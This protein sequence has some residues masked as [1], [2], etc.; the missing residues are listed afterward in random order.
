MM[1]K[2][3]KRK[4]LK[5]DNGE[6][7]KM[8]K[9]RKNRNKEKSNV[10]KRA[11]DENL[12]G[13]KKRMNQWLTL[14]LIVMPW[15]QSRWVRTGETPCFLCTAFMRYSGFHTNVIKSFCPL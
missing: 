7:R 9:G 14:Q 1:N 13:R 10:G 12:E 3:G 11:G 2:I 6:K 4:E 8:K 15:K 5:K